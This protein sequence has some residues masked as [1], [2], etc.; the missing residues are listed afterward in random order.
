LAIPFQAIHN[1]PEYIFNDRW[2]RA[3]LFDP[4]SEWIEGKYPAIRRTSSGNHINYTRH[5]DFWISNITYLRLRNLEL[6]YDLPK[7][8]VNKAHL[9]GVK[10]YVSGTNVLTFDNVKHIEM[11]P[12]IS[13]NNGLVYPVVKLYTF[14]INITL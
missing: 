2:H 8:L 3:D 10:V 4:N 6:M 5:S 1:S 12:E 14:G 11:D 7:R 9:S 13:Q